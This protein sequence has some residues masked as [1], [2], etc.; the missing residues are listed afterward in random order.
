MYRTPGS[1]ARYVP[2]STVRVANTRHPSAK[3]PLAV[4]CGTDDNHDGTDGGAAPGPALYSPCSLRVD[5]P[6]GSFSWSARPPVLGVLELQLEAAMRTSMQAAVGFISSNRRSFRPRSAP[7]VHV[8]ARQSQPT[9]MASRSSACCHLPH[10]RAAAPACDLL[11]CWRERECR[12]ERGE[13]L[14]SARAAMRP[15]GAAAASASRRSAS[16][17]VHSTALAMLLRTLS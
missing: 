17:R 4:A 14:C 2:Y 9:Q 7:R 16:P 11:I 10:G 5:S 13:R 8:R 3:R 12:H 15:P 1:R 6:T